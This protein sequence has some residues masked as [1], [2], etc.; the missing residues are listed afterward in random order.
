MLSNFE[1][2]RRKKKDQRHAQ[3]RLV[4]RERVFCLDQKDA[5]K[6]CLSY[7]FHKLQ[8]R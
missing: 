6:E 1:I 8:V 3:I 4:H 5:I 2:M 7:N